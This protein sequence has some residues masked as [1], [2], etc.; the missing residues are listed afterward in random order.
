MTLLRTAYTL[1]CSANYLLNTVVYSLVSSVSSVV[2][3][4]HRCRRR[5][6]LLN[7]WDYLKKK[8]SI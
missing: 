7:Q 6:V 8:K 5:H 4:H 1:A 3:N 2:V